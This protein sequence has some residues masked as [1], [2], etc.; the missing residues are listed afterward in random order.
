MELIHGIPITEYCNS[1]RINTDS[2]STS[3]T[4]FAKPF[5][6]HTSRGSFR[7]IVD[8]QLHGEPPSWNSRFLAF[9]SKI[10]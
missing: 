6:M 9:T 2:D 10:P 4:Q 8:G 3:F 7:K 1:N 5:N